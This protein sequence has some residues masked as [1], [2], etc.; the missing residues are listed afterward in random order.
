MQ[1]MSEAGQLV[2]S[3]KESTTSR[4]MALL[5]PLLLLGTTNVHQ[6]VFRDLPDLVY[7]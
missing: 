4:S 2:S 6:D 7:M 5:I 1:V 3:G